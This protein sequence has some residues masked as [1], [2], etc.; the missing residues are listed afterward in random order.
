MTVEYREKYQLS[1]ATHYKWT[2]CGK[3]FNTKTGRRIKQV[4][5]NGCLGY[6]IRGRF[7]S[8]TFLRT[9]IEKITKHKTPF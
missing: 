2:E 8:L 1:F 7:Y 4:Y 6:N 5:N 9:K 3:C